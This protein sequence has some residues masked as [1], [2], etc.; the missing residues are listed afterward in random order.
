MSHYT[1]REREAF[2]AGAG[3]SVA[4]ML[5][6]WIAFEIFFGCLLNNCEPRPVEYYTPSDFVRGGK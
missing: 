3:W 4:I 5:F 1:E 6:I 2:K